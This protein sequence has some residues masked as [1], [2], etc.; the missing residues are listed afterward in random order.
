[1]RLSIKVTS[2]V[3]VLLLLTL[4]GMAWLLIRHQERELARAVHLRAQ[5][6]LSFGEAAREYTR[7]TLS[8]AVAA[9][10]PKLIF[11]ANSATFVA[12]GTF[13]ALRKRLPE[14]TFREAAL[15]PLN[16]LNRATEEE[17]ALIQR[18]RDDPSLTELSG[19]RTVDGKEQFFVARPIRVEAK[20][21]Q[22]HDTPERA[23]PELVQRYGSTS[24]FGWKEGEIETL[25]PA[26]SK[27]ASR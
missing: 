22:C 2:V 20:C 19:F 1:M 10:T 21:M 6:V 15:R 3:A 7:E 12:R 18:F 25:P 8:P 26:E 4:G 9:H 16:P 5:T 24:G 13:E 17:A 14:Y 23:P 11:E 27:P